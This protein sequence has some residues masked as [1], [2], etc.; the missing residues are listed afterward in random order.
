MHACSLND[1]YDI[2]LDWFYS[3]PASSVEPNKQQIAYKRPVTAD[4]IFKNVF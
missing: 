4:G 3:V 1:E 2:F